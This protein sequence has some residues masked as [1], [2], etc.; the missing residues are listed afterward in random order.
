M[1]LNRENAFS[2]RLKSGPQ[3]GK[4]RQETPRGGA[5]ASI[6]FSIGAQWWRDRLLVMTLSSG[7]RLVTGNR[8]A[9]ASTQSSLMGP[10]STNGGINA[11]HA[12]YH[13]QLL[14]FAT[15]VQ[16]PGSG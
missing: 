3:G 4:T 15:T 16:E 1:I 11:G 12:R 10:P 8:A 13:G 7:L 2:R 5:T 9:W 6:C 14:G